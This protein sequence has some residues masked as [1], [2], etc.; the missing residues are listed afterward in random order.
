M[1]P[2]GTTKRAM[3]DEHKQALA[4]GRAHSQAVR[5]YLE[6]LETHKPK[7]G[8]KRTPESIAKQLAKVE[9]ELETADAMKRLMLVQTQLDL[10]NELET[11]DS[12]VDLSALEA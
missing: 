4:E 8:R 3:S 12:G 11:L 2:K 6:A 5:S 9:A 10:Q 1:A 7:R